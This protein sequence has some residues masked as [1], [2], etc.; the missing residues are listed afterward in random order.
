MVVAKLCVLIS[1]QPHHVFDAV[2][3]CIIRELVLHLVCIL[4]LRWIL[5]V[6]EVQHFNRIHTMHPC[7]SPAAGPL[8]LVPCCCSGLPWFGSGCCC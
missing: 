6:L 3:V 5:V 4:E 7:W 2:V 8:L 1:L